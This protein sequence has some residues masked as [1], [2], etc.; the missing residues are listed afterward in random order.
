VN[1]AMTGISG[2]RGRF[3]LDRQPHWPGRSSLWLL[4]AAGCL[5]QGRSIASPASLSSLLQNGRRA[6]VAVTLLFAPVCGDGARVEVNPDLPLPPASVQKIVTSI[7]ALDLLGPDHRFTTRL[8][9]DRPPRG[10]RLEGNLYLQ[11]GGDPFLVSERLWLLSREAGSTGLREVTGDLVVDGAPVA[12]LDSL[13]LAERSDSP[14][15]APVSI[16]GVNFNSLAFLVRPGD[17]AGAP[18][19][20]ES[21]PFSIPG[22]A[23]RNLVRTVSADSTPGAVEA[24]RSFDGATEVWTLKGSVPA[25]SPPVTVYRACRRPDL[26]AGGI[27]TGFLREAGIS[28]SGVRAGHAPEGAPVIVEFA[29]PSVGLLVRSMNVWSNN[30]MADLLLVDLGTDGSAAS[31][32]ARLRSWLRERVGMDAMPIVVDGCGLSPSDR[33]SAGQIVRLL[34][35]AHGQEKVFPDLYASFPRPG[36]E[37]TLER[38]FKKG[39][40]PSI[41]AKTGTLGDVGVSSIAGYVD[42]G[43]GTRYAFC[44]IQ[45]ARAGSGLRV[46]DLREREERWIREFVTD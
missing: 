24:N 40:V 4:V 12:D 2:A 39:S 35:W 33:I 45:Q 3:P 20:A 17:A 14:Y 41:R 11:G 10:G 26:L 38:R 19:F 27:L 34:S 29:S 1:G 36:G 7:A 6:E 28:V 13:R 16:L 9:G 25:G 32:A 22:L 31:G 43:D 42:R 37:G 30:F 15:A 23:V 18:A 46:A 44:I 8:L 5:L 21:T